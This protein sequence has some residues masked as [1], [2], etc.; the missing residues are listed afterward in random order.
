MLIVLEI[1]PTVKKC[2]ESNAFDILC[3]PSAGDMLRSSSIAISFEC[4]ILNLVRFFSFAF[5]LSSV[6]RFNCIKLFGQFG[7]QPMLSI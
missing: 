2:T 7:N 3:L 1:Y 4:G 5:M 6:F